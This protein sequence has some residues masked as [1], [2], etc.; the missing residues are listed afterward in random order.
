M[1]LGGS[2]LTNSLPLPA[3]PWPLASG[4][5]WL[6]SWALHETSGGSF[7]GFENLA[8]SK[9]CGFQLY[10]PLRSKSKENHCPE[11]S[12]QAKLPGLS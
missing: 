2:F 11:P 7:Q 10:F 8:R 4:F 5:L 1:V 3:T 12:C 9:S 6:L